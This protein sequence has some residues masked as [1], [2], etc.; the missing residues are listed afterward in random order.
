MKCLLF[1]ILCLCLH[2]AEPPK[3]ITHP[4]GLKVAVRGKAA[5]FTV[6]ATGTE[7]LTYQ[8]QWKPAEEE[9]GGVEWQ[10]CPAEWCDG[11]AILIPMKK[12]N[13]GSYRCVISNCAG[14]QT[15]EPAKLNEV[16]YCVSE[17][18][19]MCMIMCQTDR[20]NRKIRKP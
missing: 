1:H 17:S 6:Q 7:P 5:K 19:L 11:A 8:W 2:V 12:S 14:R 3:I 20:I 16:S 10:P 4:N 13:E 18:H 15:S 9:G